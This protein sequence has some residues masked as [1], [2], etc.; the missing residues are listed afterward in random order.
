[1]ISYVTVRYRTFD[2]KVDRSD[3]I[4]NIISGTKGSY[5]LYHS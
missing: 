4:Y 3:P 2:I 5:L 1:M